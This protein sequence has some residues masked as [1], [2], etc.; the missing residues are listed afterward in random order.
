VPP[1]QLSRVEKGPLLGIRPST[2]Q[3]L[4]L[5]YEA[6]PREAVGLVAGAAAL[7]LVPPAFAVV[8]G[9]LVAAAADGVRAGGLGG[10]TAT[11]FAVLVVAVALI[12]FLGEA[13]RYLLSAFVESFRLRVEGLRR[14]RVMA[15]SLRPSGVLHLEDPETADLIRVAAAP[16]WPDTGNFA[17]G[18]YDMVRRAAMAGASAVLIAG[19][20]WWLGLGFLAFWLWAARALRAGQG[21]VWADT[22]REMRRTSYLRDLAFQQPAA[23]EVRIFGLAHWLVDEFSAAWFRVMREVWRRRRA[24]RVRRA[25]LLTLVIA[26]H[27][28]AFFVVAEAARTGELDAA[29]LVVVVPA[30]LGVARFAEMDVNTFSITLGAVA[31]PAVA[32]LERRLAEEPAYQASGS[33]PAAGLPARAIRFEDVHFTYPHAP[34]PVCS[35]FDLLIEAGRSLAVVGANGAGK[36]TMVKLLARLYEPTAGRITVDDVD[37]RDIDPVQWQQRIAAVFQDFV[38]YDLTAADNVGFGAPAM[39]D[40]RAALERAASRAGATEIVERLPFGWD[41]VLS[42]QYEGGVDLSGGQW[43][44]LA[45]ARALFAVEAGASV[46]VLDEPTAN[47][48]VRAEVELFDRFLEVT[49]GLTTVLISHR[50]S[51]VRRADRIVVVDGGRVVE[52]GSHD[53]LVAAGGRYAR[54]FALQ[55]GRYRESAD[56][57][58]NDDG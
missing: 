47:L 39:A 27:A 38:H 45:L 21:E 32:A 55:A 51:T 12:F 35:G 18:V 46:L 15:A 25:G 34:S 13:G 23:K 49:R 11:R 37:M 16:D 40:D 44:R 53:E 41:T 33:L 9:A 48:D 17:V 43:Q 14:E 56:P 36:T 2:R 29:R 19:F 26:L 50:F 8:S 1:E 57:N 4:R 6:H 5:M 31:L 20:R 22:A 3:G 54:A 42:R 58:S 10:G 24:N 28:W 30:I 7:G 52:Q